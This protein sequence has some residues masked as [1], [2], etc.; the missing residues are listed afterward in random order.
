[1][2]T[3]RAEP[4]R[5]QATPRW[6]EIDL[7][8]F[9]A[10]AFAPPTPERFEW[11][12]RPDLPAALARLWEELDCA[13]KFPGFTPYSGYADY[14]ST[15]IAVFDVGVPQPPVPL[16]ESAHSKAQPAQQ[17]VLENVSFY[18]VLG[19][20]ADPARYAPDHLVTQLEFLAAVRYARENAPGTEGRE[21]LARL[22]RD[23]LERHLLSWLPAAQKKLDREQPPLY[24]VL[25][26]LLLTS[27]RRQHAE[28]SAAI[29]QSS[30]PS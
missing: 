13:G 23:F 17:T 12:C 14:E 8:R 28:L 22:E 6:A 26:I 21:S 27:L 4:R 2:A 9:F 29:E 5:K 19:L 18:E 30:R 11:L 20:K 25:L 24:P 16:L 3:V 7:Y 1:M 10:F 15:Y